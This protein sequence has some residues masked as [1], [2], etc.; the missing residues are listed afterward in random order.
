MLFKWPYLEGFLAATD[1]ETDESWDIH[2]YNMKN[3]FWAG[4]GSRAALVKKMFGADYE[5]LLW[6]VFLCFHLQKINLKFFWKYCSVCTEKL[7]SIKVKKVKKSLESIF[8]RGKTSFFRAKNFSDQSSVGSYCVSSYCIWLWQEQ[9]DF[10]KKKMVGKLTF[11]CL[12]SHKM[13]KKIVEGINTQQSSQQ[14]AVQG[15]YVLK[16]T[17]IWELKF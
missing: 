17:E 7:H 1:K 9:K 5:Q 16:Y 8:Y 4:L 10:R 13:W 12:K 11:M 6:P 2:I 15:D 3:Q 14:G